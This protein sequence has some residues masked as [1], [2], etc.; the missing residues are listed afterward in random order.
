MKLKKHTSGFVRFMV[1]KGNEG[2]TNRY[3][4]IIESIFF[5]HWKAGM[6]EFEFVRKEIKNTA[7]R[8]QIILPEN[9][10]DVPYSFRYRIPLP[11]RIV[12]TQPAGLQW[13]IEGAGRSRYRFKLVP[14]TRVKPNL[15]LA[16]ITIPDAT[17]ELGSGLI[18]QSQNMTVAAMQM[19]EKK[20][21]AQR[22]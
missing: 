14:A 18:D 4:A 19:A 13:I 10:G 8:L 6:R 11:Q 21:W 5:E 17:P 12:E 1:K 16:A 22:S 2:E 7:D 20:V 15:A 9:I 3:K